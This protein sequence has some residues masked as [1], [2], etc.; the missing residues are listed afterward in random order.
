MSGEIQITS[1]V[2]LADGVVVTPSLL[3]ELI[4]SLSAEILAG[5]VGSRELAPGSIS[6]D[7]LD[8]TVRSQLGIPDGSITVAKLADGILS[9]DATGR[10]KMADGFVTA[11]LIALATITAD[12]LATDIVW[13]VG[14]I[15]EWPNE[16]A[17]AGWLWLNGQAVSRTTYATLFALVGTRHGQGDGSTTFNVPDTRGRFKRGWDNGAGVDPDAASRT[18]AATGG[19]TGDHV[20]SLQ[21]DSVNAH[22][23]TL[24]GAVAP[25][26][27]AGTKTLVNPTGT[28]TV[29][30]EASAGGTETRPVNVA[31]MDIIK[32]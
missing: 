26:T 30:T 29:N 3:R 21:A 9:A 2:T 22:T 24:K 17:P 7:K 28:V 13:P 14:A 18:A 32:F 6:E 19:A 8:S 5:A 12:R 10:A 20:G 25:I 23:H 4:T 27:G 15:I 16:V 11:A 31:F 1:N